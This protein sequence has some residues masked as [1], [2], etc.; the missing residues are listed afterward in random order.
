MTAYNIEV[1]TEQ[2]DR[3]YVDVARRYNVVIIHS[4][5][6]LELRV[7]PRTDGELWD[8]PFATFKVDEPEVAALE[9]DMMEE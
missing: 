5:T 9:A 6:G 2:P 3:I 8:A 4:E 1:I 7:Y